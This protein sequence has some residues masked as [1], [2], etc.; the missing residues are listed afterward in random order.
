MTKVVFLSGGNGKGWGCWRQGGGLT[1][2]ICL[3]VALGFCWSRQAHTSSVFG[4]AHFLYG[5]EKH[6]NN[7]GEPINQDS[8]FL[9]TKQLKL[10]LVNWFQ[11]MA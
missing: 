11:N 1:K 8:S 9:Y 7:W 6:A 3:L 4:E 5:K 2:K 10:S